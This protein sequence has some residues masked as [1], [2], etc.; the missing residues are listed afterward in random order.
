MNNKV[1]THR[2]YLRL[3][4]DDKSGE[5]MYALF[6]T[7][8]REIIKVDNKFNCEKEKNELNNQNDIIFNHRLKLTELNKLYQEKNQDYGDAFGE[9][10]DRWG[11]VAY[12][13]RA[14]D[15]FSRLSTLLRNP[16]NRQV[17][18]ET[19]HDTVDDLLNYTIMFAI[20]LIKKRADYP[21]RLDNASLHKRISDLII[22]NYKDYN[23]SAYGLFR[24]ARYNFDT[25]VARTK[26]YHIDKLSL[27]LDIC[28]AL[29]NLSDKIE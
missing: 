10:V 11:S 18:D 8:N 1:K 27:I 22:T 3:V 12:Y 19:I 29:L 5:T 20:S 9:S 6:D 13:V 24:D 16:N 26:A 2:Y 7:L 14:G 25:L 4:G 17:K 23:R 21:G 28:I 15:K